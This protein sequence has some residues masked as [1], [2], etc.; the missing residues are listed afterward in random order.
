VDADD[1]T[2]LAEVIGPTDEGI[3]LPAV[4]TRPNS[5][6]SESTAYRV[7]PIAQI[8][9][10]SRSVSVTT[11]VDGSW[12]RTFA[13]STA[14][15]LARRSAA[16]CAASPKRFGARSRP[17]IEAMISWLV[18]L[19]PWISR[20]LAAKP[21]AASRAIAATMQIAMKQAARTWTVCRG[22][23]SSRCIRCRRTW[24]W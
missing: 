9:L 23:P 12:T 8:S 11:I 3:G 6:P 21:G 20:V 15:S 13:D 4:S 24:L 2:G 14:G 7:A 22:G 18:N 10:G 1:S 19:A 17:T 5:R 16:S